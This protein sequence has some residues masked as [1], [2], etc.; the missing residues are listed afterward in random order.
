MSIGKNTIDW[1]KVAYTIEKALSFQKMRQGNIPKYL[2]TLRE[3]SSLDT[4]NLLTLSTSPEEVGV[5]LLTLLDIELT[6]QFALDIEVVALV[7][8]VVAMEMS[9]EVSLD[10][11]SFLMEV[12]LNLQSFQMKV[13]LK[14][15]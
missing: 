1:N 14:L 10:L 3:G 7:A 2:W 13:S 11:E 5:V 12:S 8:L 6:S 4:C 15:Q 9:M